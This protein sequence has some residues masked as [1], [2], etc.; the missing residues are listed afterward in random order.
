M[1]SNAFAKVVTK[2]TTVSDTI[3]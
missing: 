1:R 2:G 3:E